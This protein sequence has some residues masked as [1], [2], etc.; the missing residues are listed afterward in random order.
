[1]NQTFNIKRALRYSKYQ[2]IMNRRST[3]TKLG[4]FAIA[5]FALFFTMLM[6]AEMRNANDYLVLF[7]TIFV[8]CGLLFIGNSFSALRKKDETIQFLSIP[9]SSFE[10]FSYEYITKVVLYILLYP[11]V[12]LL[13]GKLAFSVC[14]IFTGVNPQLD[15]NT[16]VTFGY[17]FRDFK[18]EPEIMNILIAVYFLVSSILLSGA[19]SFKKLPLVKTFLAVGVLFG[20]IV[21]YFYIII[22]KLKLS[23]GIERGTEAIFIT[24]L[25]LNPN[26]APSVNILLAPILL[27]AVAFVCYSYYKIKEKEV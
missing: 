2:L 6:N 13:I 16:V 7:Y 1:M 8:I 4:G 5:L 15:K 3:L 18:D 25:D 19:A 11:L 27:L 12:F 24:V 26:K 17:L 10:K 14:S 21:G 9:A 22:E 23:N 20:V